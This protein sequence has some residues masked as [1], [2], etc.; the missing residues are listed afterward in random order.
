V[1]GKPV[2]IR[3]RSDG[4]QERWDEGAQDVSGE[5]DDGP[6]LDR[7]ARGIIVVLSLKDMDARWDDIPGEVGDEQEVAI[8]QVVVCDELL[9]V[10]AGED[11][12]LAPCPIKSRQ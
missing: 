4:E 2:R 3:T 7:V 8:Q 9:K 10:G 6:K 5:R 11:G 12:Y 1:G